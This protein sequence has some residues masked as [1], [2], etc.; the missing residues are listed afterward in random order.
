MS[1]T[2]AYKNRMEA[3]LTE[4]IAAPFLRDKGHGPTLLTYLERL[5]L[6]VHV[7]YGIQRLCR[8]M[9]EMPSKELSMVGGTEE[10]KREC[11]NRATEAVESFLDMHRLSSLLCRSWAFVHNAVSC[12]FALQNLGATGS[13]SRANSVVSRLVVVLENEEVQATWQDLDT[14]VRY[15][16]PYSRASKALKQAIATTP[17]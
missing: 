9:L 10:T 13:R 1:T 7:C 15:F 11:I 5:A 2:I 4:E 16:G 3:I 17:S 14:N 8:L 6:R 12:A